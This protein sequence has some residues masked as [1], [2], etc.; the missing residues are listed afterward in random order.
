[1]CG[2]F[3]EDIG[4]ETFVVVVNIVIVKIFFI[5]VAILDWECLQFDFETT[6]LNSL[7][8][9]KLVYVKQLLGFQDSTH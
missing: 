7:L 1:M 2:N 4:E 9:G 6:F 5:I 8:E 3:E